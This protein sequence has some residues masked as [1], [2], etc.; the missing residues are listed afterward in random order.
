MDL[1]V[2]IE[3]GLPAL[4][5]DAISFETGATKAQVED[6]HVLAYEH[7][8]PEFSASDRGALPSFYEDLILGRP[9][10]LTL[11]T[12]ALHDIDTLTAIALFLHRDLATHPATTGFVYTVDFVHRLGFQALAHIETDLAR[13]I[14]VL[15]NQFPENGLSQSQLSERITTSVGWIREYIHHG[16]FPTLG[17]APNSD[18]RVIDIGTTG[19]VLANTKGN[20]WD[21]WAELYR[22]GHLRGV[23]V[24]E[25]TEDR[26]QVL[27][28]RKSLWVPFNLT[29]ASRVLNEMETAMGELPEWRT[30]S[31]ELWLEGP[32]EGTLILL[33][34]LMAVLIRV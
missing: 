13:F 5:P 15:R 24:R 4:V 32:P 21:G 7:H 3:K 14:T 23:L 30:T 22:R 11:A 18:V 27:V 8:G 26:R 19:F 33:Q 16:T 28:A 9:M 2:R 6:P 1:N 10:P 25:H 20:L 17:V 29:T 34:H 12:T 31:D